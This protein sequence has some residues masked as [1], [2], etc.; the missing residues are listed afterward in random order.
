MTEIN[1][2]RAEIN[3][4]R[5]RIESSSRRIAESFAELMRDNRVQQAEVDDSRRRI[6]SLRIDIAGLRDESQEATAI[7][8][9]LGGLRIPYDKDQAFSMN[10]GNFRG[11]NAVSAQGAFRLSA[12][13]DVVVDIGAAHGLEYHQTGFKA[14]ITWSW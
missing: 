4:N 10:I 8:I 14:G 1:R 3:R 12:D 6:D 13:P 7:A 2:N 9:A 5:E 11:K